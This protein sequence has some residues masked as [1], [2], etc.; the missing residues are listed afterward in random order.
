M[1]AQISI[2]SDEAHALAHKLARE[3]HRTVTKVIELALKAYAREHEQ[4]KEKQSARDFVE[5][6]R[7]RDPD[8]T[9][10]IDLEALIREDRKPHD[11]IDLE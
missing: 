8:D 3:Q 9:I 4:Q 6:L 5:M 2:R 1:G 7:T 10:D 11:G